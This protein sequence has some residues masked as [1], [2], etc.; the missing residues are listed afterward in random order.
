MRSGQFVP[1]R[2]VSEDLTSV[3]CNGFVTY[4]ALQ[5]SANPSED[6][7]EEGRKEQVAICLLTASL[8]LEIG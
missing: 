4:G 8:G 1:F 7:N 5:D 6:S 2:V 3:A